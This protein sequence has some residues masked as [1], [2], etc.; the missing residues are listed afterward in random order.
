MSPRLPLTVI[1]G[2]LGAGK[3]TL[4]NRILH[5]PRGQ[6]IM[7]L[8]NDFGAINIDASL[9]MCADEDTI[10]LTNGCVCC[11]MGAD[12]FLAI[13][14]VLDRRQRPDHLIV[15]A[16]GIADPAKI[17]AVAACEPEL[18]HAGIVA[19]FDGA[20]GLSLLD[21]PLI[22]DQVRSQVEVADLIMI[23]K[24]PSAKV[25]DRIR[26]LAPA[27]EIVESERIGALILDRLALD[28]STLDRP[29]PDRPAPESAGPI[30]ESPASKE[31]SERSSSAHPDYV[32]WHASGDIAFGRT[33]LE[34]RLKRRPSG[35]YRIKGFVRQLHATGESRAFEVQVTGRRISIKSAPSNAQSGIVAIGI[36]GRITAK[37]IERWWND[38]SSDNAALAAS[39]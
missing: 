18:V 26:L 16:S 36:E 10:A 8:V 14:D 27:G 11:T 1:G 24:E 2:Y 25:I 22:A 35:L 20:N 29:D 21:D 37:E 38:G 7:V 23:S 32:S 39:K 12:L 28:P 5:A 13:G 6:R 31:A 33:V 4:I 3:T 19:V 30:P 15:E 9:L 17:A 34:D